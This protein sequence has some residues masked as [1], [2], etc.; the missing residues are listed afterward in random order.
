MTNIFVCFCNK[1]TD[2]FLL[3]KFV[4][5]T[6]T[7]VPDTVEDTTTRCCNDKFGIFIST[8]CVNS[9]VRVR[10]LDRIMDVNVTG[11]HCKQN[12][13]HVTIQTGIF[14]IVRRNGQI[15]HTQCNVLSRC[16]NRFTVRR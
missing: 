14:R 1:F 11:I 8:G 13:M 16:R 3:H 5:E 10:D 2:F 4:A 9:I 15:V 7:L 12:F 6:K